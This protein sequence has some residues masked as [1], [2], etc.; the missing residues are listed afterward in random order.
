M[1]TELS[2]RAFTHLLGAGAALVAFPLAAKVGTS[3]G[4][5]RLSANENPYGLSD[6][7]LRAASDALRLAWRY[8]DEAQDALAESIAHLHG[9]PTDEVLVGD[10][11]SEILKIAVAAFIGPGRS[12]VLAD[13]TFE[14][15]AQHAGAAKAEIVKVPLDAAHGHDLPRMLEVKNAGLIYICNPNNPTATITRKDRVS[16]FLEAVPESTAVLV[17]EAYFHYAEGDD[18]ATVAPLVQKH[19]NLIVARTFSKIY[20][21]AGLRCGYCVAQKSM[22]ARLDAERAWDTMNIVALAAANASLADAALVPEARKRNSATRLWLA[23]ALHDLGLSMLP[24]QANFV[25][26][27]MHRDVRP[28]ISALRDRGVRVGRL[29]PAM[30][31][32]L[33]VTIG[34]PEEMKRFVTA[35]AEVVRG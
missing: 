24:S 31:Q 2:R 8:P 7:A 32:H 6:A 29:F 3:P 10:G 35:L 18:Y 15:V 11:S 12:L 22:I 4:I 23:N 20:G 30:P 14:A 16:D 21:M 13:P 25:M 5:V 34:K 26:I 19:P 9:C 17:D 27:E 1:Q 28:V 33:R